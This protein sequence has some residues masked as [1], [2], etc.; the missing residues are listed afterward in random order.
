VATTSSPTSRRTARRRQSRAAVH[1]QPS[2][3]VHKSC[4]GFVWYRGE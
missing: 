3:T 4:E 1:G 2:F